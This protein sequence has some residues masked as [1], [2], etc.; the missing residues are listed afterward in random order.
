MTHQFDAGIAEIYGVEIAI[1][2][3][4]F[5][6]WIAKNKANNRNFYEGKTWTYN[7][8]KA[9]NELFPYWSE[10]QIRR[11]L[12]KMEAEGILLTGNF[13]EVKY[14]R[15]I[16]Y[17]FTNA[18]YEKHKCILQNR[19]MEVT[20]PSNGSDETVTP[21]PD[22]L[23]V[24]LPDSLSSLKNKPN[25]QSFLDLYN[26]SCPSLPR[27]TRVTDKRRGS[28]NAVIKEFGEDAVKE[29]L[30]KVESCPH[31][32]GKNDRGWKA[33]FDWLINK[34]NLLKVIEGR[35]DQRKKLKEGDDGYY[36]NDV[37]WK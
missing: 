15:T 31:L 1:M 35:Y 3:Q 7:T 29:A 20:K 10:S 36:E 32:V 27:A 25:Y 33:D 37:A 14:D 22:K 13:N 34:N 19:Q 5:A 28:I 11:I 23:P 6:F 30:L 9:F 12:K 2:V 4:N 17:T 26:E 8:I 21:I 18:F 16:W 24:I